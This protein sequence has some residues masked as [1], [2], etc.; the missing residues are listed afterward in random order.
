MA[1]VNLTARYL[2]QLHSHGKR[3]EVFDAL[4]PGLASRVSATGQK[5]FTL[6]YRHHGRMR[7]VGLGRYP[8]VLLEK[9]RKMATQQRGRI[10]DGADPAGDK[11]TDHAQDEHTVQA[12]YDLYRSHKKKTLRC[13]SEVRRIME[14]D[15][16]RVIR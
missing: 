2:D 7:R 1:T 13:W 15:G 8:D 14:R 6:Y 16:E 10:F 12:L 11:Q 9:A 3:Y 4:V 5:T